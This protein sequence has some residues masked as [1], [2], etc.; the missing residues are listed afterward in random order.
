VTITDSFKDFKQR[1]AVYF[2][3]WEFIFPF[4]HDQIKRYFD[5]LPPHAIVY[6]LVGWTIIY[7][8]IYYIWTEYV[9]ETRVWK[10]LQS[11]RQ[12]LKRWREDIHLTKGA[13]EAFPQSQRPDDY[14]SSVIENLHS[15][16]SA[17]LLLLSGYTMFYDN[18]HYLLDEIGAI[19]KST[20]KEFSVLLLN[21][22]SSAF[23]SRGSV[24][25][26]RLRARSNTDP[27]HIRKMSEYIQR[28]IDIRKQLEKLL[29]HAKIAYYD[30][31]PTWRLHIFDNYLFMSSYDEDKDGHLTEAFRIPNTHPMYKAFNIYFDRLMMDVRKNA[32]WT[33]MQR[34][35]SD[36]QSET[37]DEPEQN[38]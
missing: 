4:V 27:A 23:K 20:E 7:F 21:P 24:F 30:S 15:S 6:L 8:L 26:R 37:K 31:Q 2:I 38:N 5:V 11:L 36:R 13:I 32:R 16:R 18:E 3:L 33:K 35:S 34:R 17:K 12:H 14:K 28:A 19:G 9:A 25:V 10:V 29:P 22:Y 1:H